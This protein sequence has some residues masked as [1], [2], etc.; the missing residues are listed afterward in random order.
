MIP[1]IAFTRTSPYL[2]IGFP[3]LINSRSEPYQIKPVISPCRC[4]GSASKPFCD[5]AHIKNG[6]NYPDN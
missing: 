3:G 6:F 4:G 1:V 2:L 5:G